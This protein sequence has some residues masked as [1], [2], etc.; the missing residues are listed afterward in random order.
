MSGGGPG[1]EC[2]HWS[3]IQLVQPSQFLQSG[4]WDWIQVERWW[5]RDKGTNK[6]ITK[7][8]LLIMP[9]FLVS[10]SHFL[11]VFCLILGSTILTCYDW[12]EDQHAEGS[13]QRSSGALQLEPVDS[14]E[15]CNQL[16]LPESGTALSLVLC[17]YNFLSCPLTY[18]FSLCYFCLSPFRPKIVQLSPETQ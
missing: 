5:Q 8:S 3:S 15:K 12:E 1:A 13:L 6:P 16:I 10:V 14:L 7:K 4:A 18:S 9:V 17:L 2:D 11:A